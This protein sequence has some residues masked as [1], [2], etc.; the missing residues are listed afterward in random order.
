MISNIRAHCVLHECDADKMY[1]YI[2]IQFHSPVMKYT[3]NIPC[4]LSTRLTYNVFLSGLYC[5]SVTKLCYLL[6]RLTPVSH[7][8]HTYPYQNIFKEQ[9]V[10]QERIDFGVVLRTASPECPSQSVHAGI[11]RKTSKQTVK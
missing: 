4:V 2:Y 7:L 8:Y 1:I 11:S 5:S 3:P 6:V 9:K 10:L